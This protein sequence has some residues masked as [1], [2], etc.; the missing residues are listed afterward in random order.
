MAAAT[1]QNN[2]S[3][4]LK[5][6]TDNSSDLNKKDILQV[7][8]AKLNIPLTA[9]IPK[10][11]GFVAYTDNIHDIEKLLS[12]NAINLL[13]KINC[14]PKA[15][16]YL[17]QNKTLLIR[18]LDDHVLQFTDPEIIA[19]IQLQNEH[20]KIS[21]IIRIPNRTRFCKIICDD[22]YTAEKLL[23]QGLKLFNTKIP[24]SNIHQDT[25]AKI[26]ICFSCYAM[27]SH[28]TKDCPHKSNPRCSNCSEWGH[29]HKS[30]P[31]PTSAKCIN[32]S[33]LGKDHS[34]HTLALKCPYRKEIVKQ[35]N[36]KKNSVPRTYSDTT[37]NAPIDF[38]AIA[39]DIPPQRIKAYAALAVE[40]H[41]YTQNN[42]GSY[43][44]R[45]EAS[46]LSTFGLSLTLPR[47]SK[48][49]PPP[50]NGQ[51]IRNNYPRARIPHIPAL[52]MINP[53][54]VQR[55]TNPTR[56]V[57][58]STR[59]ATN[60]TRFSHAR[61][62]PPN[63]NK[64]K[65]PPSGN[66]SSPPKPPEPPKTPNNST[67]NSGSTDASLPSLMSPIT[68]EKPSQNPTPQPSTTSQPPTDPSLTIIVEKPSQ[69]PTPQPPTTPL[70]PNN[71]QSRSR[72]T[73]PSITSNNRSSSQPP[74][75]S[76]SS[77][78]TDDSTPQT[79]E[80]AKEIIK[81]YPN[82]KRAL[83][84]SFLE[85]PETTPLNPYSKQPQPKS[86]KP[87]DSLEDTN[88]EQETLTQ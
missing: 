44:D 88:T 73:S 8:A 35:I 13:A 79:L 86:F 70:Q 82:R 85:N 7:T 57:T 14:T 76:P 59:F 32:C 6:N 28:P 5:S 71:R 68:V 4:F 69:K 19:E 42:G 31:N 29:F 81:T 21:E 40:A 11:T 1:P 54:V 41:V 20:T 49:R 74:S 23:K 9:L 84:Y 17:S 55:T 16:P 58:N 53:A 65:Q 33:N 25:I 37:R 66:R 30:C 51:P 12:K 36:K 46:A 87:S 61:Q 45:F 18:K 77:G 80:E 38:A 48:P 22:T 10:E 67:P 47:K 27:E 24:A 15:P 64:Q 2:F 34:H 75:R 26:Q 39:K 62:P 3:I 60:P 63:T 43:E 50:N 83:P 78:S 72:T 52:S 56:Y